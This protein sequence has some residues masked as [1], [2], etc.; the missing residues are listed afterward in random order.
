[1]SHHYGVDEIRYSDIRH[2]SLRGTPDQPIGPWHVDLLLR[3]IR[4]LLVRR[5]Q[6][7]ESRH[8]I[9]ALTT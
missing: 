8:G 2:S 6:L 1:L 7:Q 4:V 9:P 5:E 3:D